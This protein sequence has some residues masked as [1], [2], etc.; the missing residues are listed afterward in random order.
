MCGQAQRAAPKRFGQSRACVLQTGKFEHLV[1][2]G[3]F[4]GCA[5]G[6]LHVLPDIEPRK[7]ARFLKH[8]ADIAFDRDRAERVHVESGDGPQQRALPATTRT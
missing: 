7:E 3:A 6:K 8:V 4:L 5:C 2:A 1:D